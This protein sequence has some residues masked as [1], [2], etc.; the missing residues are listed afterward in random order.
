MFA[1]KLFQIQKETVCANWWNVYAEGL[2]T[3]N[4]IFRVESF[5][6]YEAC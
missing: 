3:T 2:T 4:A 1:V 5:N 6:I